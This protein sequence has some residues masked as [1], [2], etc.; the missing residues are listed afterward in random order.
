MATSGARDF[1]LTLLSCCMCV[2]GRGQLAGPS[3]AGSAPYRAEASRTGHIICAGMTKKYH[4]RRELRSIGR[5]EK[6]HRFHLGGFVAVL[7][8]ALLL[9]M[10]KTLKAAALYPAGL[11][12][13]RCGS[14]RSY[15]LFREWKSL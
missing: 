13:R 8:Q 6:N 7:P 12:Q 1:V 14:Y 10:D 15:T 4:Q 3:G 5:R 2:E 9:D 11:L